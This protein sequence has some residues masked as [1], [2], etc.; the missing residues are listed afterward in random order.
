MAVIIRMRNKLFIFLLIGIA[1]HIIVSCSTKWT[2]AIR[3]GEVA[4]NQF[5]ETVDVEIRNGLIFIP[6][7]MRGKE[8]RFL[9]DTGAPFSISNKLQNDYSFEIVNKGK[10]NRVSASK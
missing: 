3:L 2:Q 7:T 6:V 4:Q 1:F 8:Y 10:I 5:R 9:F